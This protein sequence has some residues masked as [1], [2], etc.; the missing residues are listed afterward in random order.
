MLAVIKLGGKQYKIREQEIFKADK[1]KGEK[2]NKIEIKEVM[3]ISDDNS[4]SLVIGAPFIEG[5]K[6]VAEVIEQGREKKLDVIKYKRK[7]RYRKKIGH[8]ACYTKIK[9]LEIKN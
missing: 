4:E 6:V 8:R 5:A 9:V 1:I 3:L 2:G 7:T